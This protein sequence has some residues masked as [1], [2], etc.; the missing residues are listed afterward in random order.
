MSGDARPSAF[1]TASPARR[2]Y[3]KIRVRWV[4]RNAALLCAAIRVKI[5]SRRS[6]MRSL[7]KP[8]SREGALRQVMAREWREA[9]PGDASLG[10]GVAAW[11]PQHYT[12]HSHDDVHSK[13]LDSLDRT[14]GTVP[15]GGGGARKRS[16]RDSLAR[17]LAVALAGLPIFASYRHLC[18][19]VKGFRTRVDTTSTHVMLALS[20]REAR[21]RISRNGANIAISERFSFQYIIYN[22]GFVNNNLTILQV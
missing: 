2:S 12:T 20:S 15:G 7:A 6:G 17:H 10:G 22:P 21:L 19:A 8:R 18:A 9:A 3:L 11:Q 1:A 13:A 5:I 4:S 14:R 16:M